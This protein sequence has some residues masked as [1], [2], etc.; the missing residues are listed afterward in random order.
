MTAR[1]VELVSGVAAFFVGAAGWLW[2]VFGPTYTAAGSYS[3]GRDTPP[4]IVTEPGS[5][6]Q[7]QDLGS[8]PIVF[9]LALLTC[10]VAVGLG[11]YLHASRRT[12]S[13]L[14]ILVMATLFL[15]GGVVLSAFTVGLF[16]VP[17]AA[18][19]VVA[20]IAGWRVPTD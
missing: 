14:P 6:A 5:L 8:G 18:L 13:G 15:V 3:T 4:V 1:R 11:A 7:V 9:L 12:S 19:A 20:S 16:I 10:L 17:A 2:A